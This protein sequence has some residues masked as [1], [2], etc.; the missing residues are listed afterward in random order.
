[1]AGEAAAR[2]GIYIDGAFR[3]SD[4]GRVFC[5][6]ELFGFMRFACAVGDRFD[7]FLLIAR[8]TADAASTPHP[9]PGK[10]EL[11]GLPHYES[12]RQVGAVLAALPR[13]VGAMWRALDGLDA[14][15]VSGVHPFGLALAALAAMRRR[16]VVLLI[17]QNS[18]RYF[19]ARLPGP[20]WAP[21]LI[22]LR[23]L[24][25]IFLVLGRWCRTTVVGSE[26]ARRYRAPRPNVLEMRVT[27]T[28][29]SQLAAA[30][31]SADWSSQV[32]LL[33]VGRI[34]PEKNPEVA[35]E[36]LARLDRQDP[37]RYSLRWAGGG[38]RSTSLAETAADLGVADR[39]HLE[40]FVPFGRELL[41]LYG[42]A[43][44]FVHVSLT[45]GVPGVLY[46]AMGAGLPIVA[47]D[48]G[49]VRAALAGGEAGL[50]VPPSEPEAIAEAV[51]RL[52][53]DEAL[54]KRLATN[55]LE[56][57]H[58]ATLESESGRVARFIAEAEN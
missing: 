17:R 15:W 1:V 7:R 38:R 35:V 34:E 11:T 29:R 12:L 39:L 53:A 25:A 4:Q 9:L 36:A 49:G 28:E 31:S 22:P 27:L 3:S 20:L 56:L 54:R 57:A 42:E 23:I 55:A 47:T 41:R 43:H 19:R 18:P 37:G 58:D 6:D 48:V 51:R 32:D 26:I 10:L 30:P 33:S 8:G 50:L 2:L 13:T 5:G 45:E 16:R 40:G 14:V 24:D 46:E 21:L 44:A 52:S